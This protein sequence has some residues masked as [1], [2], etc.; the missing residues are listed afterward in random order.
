[1][2][3]LKN[4]LITN[5][6]TKISQIE[7]KDLLSEFCE[8][9]KNFKYGKHTSASIEYIKRDMNIKCKCGSGLELKFDTFSKIFLD[10]CKMCKKEKI[11]NII[12]EQRS[13]EINYTEDLYNKNKVKEILKET[14]ITKYFDSGAQRKMI[15][16]N[17]KLYFSILEHTKD[18]DFVKSINLKGRINFLLN[19]PKIFCECGSSAKFN[20]HK[21]EFLKYCMKCT[22]MYPSLEWFKITY[23]D[24]YAI[25][26]QKDKEKRSGHLKG[27]NILDKYKERFGEEIGEEKYIERM[28][29]IFS[30][31][32]F[33]K[34]SQDLFWKLKERLETE[35][36]MFA[37]FGSEY[38]IPLNQDDKNIL[39]QTIIFLDFKYK[40][41]IIEFNGDYWHKDNGTREKDLKK[42]MIC[43][44]RGFDVLFVWEN[45]YKKEPEK[46]IERCLRFLESPENVKFNDRFLIETVNGYEP[47]DNIVSRGT[48]KQLKITTEDSEISVS[49][50]HIFKIFERDVIAK[51]LKIGDCL[52]YKDKLTVI[53]NIEEGY[54]EIY[55]VLH[56][57]S[58]TYL[59]N[60][61][62]NHNCNFLGSS[63]TLISS[64]KLKQMESKEPDEIRDGKLKIYKYPEKGHKYILTVDPSMGVQGDFFAV[65]IVDITDIK[66]KQVATARLN[67]EYLKLPEFLDEWG[68]YFNNALIIIENNTGSGQSIADILYQTYEYENLYFDKETKDKKRKKYPGFRT[69]AKSRK[70]IL[71]NLKMFIEN[72]K[73]EINDSDTITEF[74]QFILINKKYQADEGCHDDMIM[75]LALTFAIFVDTKNFEDII[76]LISD[77]F[78]D[79][80]DVSESQFSDY[81]SIGNF[82]DG[83]EMGI[84]NKG[85]YTWNGYSVEVEDGFY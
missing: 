62:N 60:N 8:I 31:N 51:T 66:F 2:K 26:V 64:E 45:E 11:S 40:N 34:I 81:L 74:F 55:D 10:S 6:I 14:D 39:D 20:S 23:G 53:L 15:K 43:E 75:S 21:D 79:E 29:K 4:Y 65:Q 83:Y 27:V 76:Q 42:K 12:T 30:E 7:D 35:E 54:G 59:A 71:D 56:T 85:V 41:K 33:S 61:I 16:E 32:K 58:N 52:Q 22:P 48:K 78:S 18:I 46:V 50:N 37:S 49:E 13:K 80:K 72:D 1:M 28:S 82:D 36:V 24:D 67:E 63:H 57:D 25:E 70:V 77:M 5:N 47:F 38:Y 73:F 84:E 69:T 44:A 3:N 19:S 68:R 17:G 9:R